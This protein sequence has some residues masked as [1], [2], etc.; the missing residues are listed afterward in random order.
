[1][2]RAAGMNGRVAGLTLVAA[3]NMRGAIQS[4]VELSTG[5]ETRTERSRDRVVLGECIHS[6]PA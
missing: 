2:A 4:P 3:R 1:M 5:I 6:G